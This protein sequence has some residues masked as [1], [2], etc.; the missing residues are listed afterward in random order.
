MA[1]DPEVQAL[2]VSSEGVTISVRRWWSADILVPVPGPVR[3]FIRQFD[4][5]EF[6]HLVAEGNSESPQPTLGAS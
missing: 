3:Q 2:M 5:G 6:A 4:N 1:A